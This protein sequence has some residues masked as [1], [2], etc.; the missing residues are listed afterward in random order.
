MPMIKHMGMNTETSQK[1]AVVFRHIYREDGSIQDNTHAL[2]VNCETLPN[3][4]VDAF[5]DSVRSSEAQDTINYFE[6]ANR[7][8]LPDGRTILPALVQEGRMVKVRSNI[9][10][11]QPD[12]G[13]KIKLDELNRLLDAQKAG[14]TEDSLR[15]QTADEVMKVVNNPPDHL[16][17]PDKQRAFQLRGQ[18]DMLKEDIS[19]MEAEAQ[20]LDPQPKR[21]RG[22]PKKQATADVEG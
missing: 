22:R 19:R 8:L 2:V 3:L 21:G 7:Q 6:V 16:M 17:S 1:V 14:H 11:M 13:I 18:A 5:M 20:D 12:H 9:I 4:W 10:E 15:T